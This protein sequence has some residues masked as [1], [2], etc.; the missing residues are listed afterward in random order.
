LTGACFCTIIVLEMTVCIGA[1]CSNLEGEPSE[2]VV[3]A[4]D[5]MV[6]LGGHTEFE[7][8]VPKITPIA[9]TI[10]AL[11]SGDALRGSRL[12][13]DLASSV[14]AGPMTVEDVAKM[15]VSR[16][17]EHRRRQIESEIFTPRGITM[18]EFYHGLQTG[19]VAGL[20][21][22]ID[23][24]VV[25]YNYDVDLLIGGVDE[26][27]GHLYRVHNPGELMDFATIA[28]TAIG[29]GA[30]HAL[31]MFIGLD[32]TAERSLRESVFSVYAAKRRAEV[33]PGV[34][35]HTDLAIILESGVTRASPPLLRR[36][37]EVYAQYQRPLS[38][39]IR[40]AIG[41]LDLFEK[42]EHDGAS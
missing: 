31:Q 30:L 11:V 27:G 17:V 18:A 39:E 19:L 28:F 1:L 15:A 8:D 4:S 9:R 42:E 34:G 33:A 14:P 6:T 22:H 26:T 29:S 32:H 35:K 7:H 5:R 20:V 25:S 23:G 24:Q 41:R 37:E 21:S 16:Y 13:R 40:Q 38:R 3:V 10:L 2:A 12:V 36:L